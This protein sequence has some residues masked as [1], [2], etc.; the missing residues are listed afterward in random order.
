LTTKQFLET[1]NWS[2]N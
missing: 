1:K 2:L